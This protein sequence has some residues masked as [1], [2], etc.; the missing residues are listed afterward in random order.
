MVVRASLKKKKD[1]H[2]V[3]GIGGQTVR[4]TAVEMPT[5]VLMDSENDRMMISGRQ[6]VVLTAWGK[7]AKHVAVLVDR[8]C[9][10]VQEK[11]QQRY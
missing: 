2:A 9:E 6:T 5:A 10:S 11:G 4:I 8:Q 7:K 1:K 3:S